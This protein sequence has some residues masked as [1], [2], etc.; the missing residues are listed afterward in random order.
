MRFAPLLIATAIAGA[1][2]LPAAAQSL[3]VRG[4]V[5]AVDGDT[6]TMDAVTGETVEVVMADGYRVILYTEIEAA[7]VPRNAWLSIPSIPG[8][9]GLKRAVSINVFPEE[10]RGL[11]EGE[12]SWD[13]GA[14]SLMTNAVAG[15]MVGQDEG[16]TMTITYE[17]T[18]EVI[19]VPEGTPITTFAPVADRTLAEGEM[20]V[21]FA[22][23]TDDGV[24][25]ANMAGVMADGT[26]P[27]L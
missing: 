26:L 3:H 12:R 18:E 22:T 17:G 2:A 9:G 10:M 11:G 8:A 21:L 7:E 23:L 16:R 27:P 13:L 25:S 24:L 5:A 6:V 15:E 19:S 4:T 14:D 1:T 20:V